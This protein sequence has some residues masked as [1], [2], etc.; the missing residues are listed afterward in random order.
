ARSINRMVNR[1]TKAK[2]KEKVTLVVARNGNRG[3][4]GRPKGVKGRYRMVDPRMK[5]DLR[6]VKA[7]EKRKKKGGRK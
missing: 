3:V 1:A 7:R 6:A 4:Q 5:A 2:P